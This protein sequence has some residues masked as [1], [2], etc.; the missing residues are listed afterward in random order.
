MA[1]LQSPYHTFTAHHCNGFERFMA[2]STEERPAARCYLQRK[3][4]NP[5]MQPARERICMQLT[6]VARASYAAREALTGA[7]DTMRLSHHT[8]MD[9]EPRREA[10][11][12][13]CSV[14][15]KDSA[16]TRIGCVQCPGR[17][18]S[19]H[20]AH[21]RRDESSSEGIDP[22]FLLLLL[23]LV[24]CIYMGRPEL[25]EKLGFHESQPMG[26]GKHQQTPSVPGTTWI[27]VFL[28][29][30]RSTPL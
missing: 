29:A 21:P 23:L 27:H 19:H 12:T 3:G 16:P 11:H 26:N 24:L 13:V 10:L 9:H 28:P 6:P 7:K 4:S 22:G 8:S 18:D 5:G 2:C 15:T 30:K 17:H 14:G 1:R 20:Q 25:A